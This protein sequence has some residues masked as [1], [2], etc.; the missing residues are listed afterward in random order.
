[1]TYEGLLLSP[2]VDFGLWP[3]SFFRPIFFLLMTYADSWP[4]KDV[5]SNQGPFWVLMQSPNIHVSKK[6]SGCQKYH[7][8]CSFAHDGQID[9][10]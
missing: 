9:F 8:F 1:M 4:L 7:V 10:I 6:V 2:E 5:C 3:Q